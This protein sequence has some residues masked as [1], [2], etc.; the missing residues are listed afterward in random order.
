LALSGSVSTSSY[1]GRYYTLSWS[2]SQS[3]ANNTST[4]SWTLSANGGNSSWYAERTLKAVIAGTTVYSKT[5]RV[6]RYAGTITSGSVTLTHNTDGSKS[7]SASLEAAVYTSS[8]NCTGS[9]SFTLDTIARKSTVSC[10]SGNIGSAVTINISRASSSF[11][12]TLTYDF[13]GLTGTIATGVGASK[14][15]TLPTSFYEKIPQATSNWGTVYCDTYSGGTWIGQTSCTFTAYVSNS[16]PGLSVSIVDTDATAIALTGDSSKLIRYYSD[17]KVTLTAT[18]KNSAWITGYSISGGGGSSTSSSATVSNVTNGSFTCKVTDSRGYTTT[19]TK[20][21]TIYNYVNLSC[22]IGDNKPSAS[23][24][25]TVTA[26]GNYYNGSFGATNNTLTVQYR[27]KVSG[28]SYSGWTNMT[29]TRASNNTYDA[30]A[31]LTIP[32]FSYK[33]TYV[34]QTRAVDKLATKNSSEK[35]VKTTP[36]FDWGESDFVFNVQTVTATDIALLADTGE[37]VA[38]KGVTTSSDR[39]VKENIKYLNYDNINTL[40]ETDD[41]ITINE[42]LD[43]VNNDYLLATYNYIYDES[44]ETRISAIAQDLMVNEDESDNKIG[45]L[46]TEHREVPVYDYFQGETIKHL[47]GINQAQLLNVAIGA[48]QALSKQVAELRAIIEELDN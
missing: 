11:T 16:T 13:C 29:V 44:K 34:F 23:G 14:S 26:S 27:Y 3:V 36:I 40:A 35:S 48:I 18:A 15:W 41:S 22:A 4:I 46:V 43:F 5:D 32:D 47:V 39:A 20:T 9:K 38:P 12:H 7:F 30:S 42:C 10:G 45:L 6:Q 1:D 37:I 2:A 17:A 31:T 8:V 28:G 24:S 33:K 25:M 21:P 19:V